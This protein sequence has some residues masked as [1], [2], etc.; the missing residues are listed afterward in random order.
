LI[1]ASLPRRLW[2][3]H[4]YS[5]RF[6]S[7]IGKFIAHLPLAVGKQPLLQCTPR[8]ILG[9]SVDTLDEFA[10]EYESHPDPNGACDLVFIDGGHE[11]ESKFHG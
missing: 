7:D 10:A 1:P 2:P 11:F 8:L 9:D 4:G 6:R 5:A 3:K